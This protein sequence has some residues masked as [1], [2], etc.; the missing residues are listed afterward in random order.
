MADDQ[1]TRYS[2]GDRVASW[3]HGGLPESHGVREPGSRHPARAAPSELARAWYKHWVEADERRAA[4]YA[5]QRPTLC[6]ATLHCQGAHTRGDY[7]CC[8]CHLPSNRLAYVL[9]SE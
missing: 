3:L 5:L 9:R 4:G 6:P 7:S 1:P 2:E 8:Q